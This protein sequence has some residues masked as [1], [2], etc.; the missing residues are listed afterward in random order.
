MNIDFDSPAVKLLKRQAAEILDRDHW[1]DNLTDE[2]IDKVLLGGQIV[3]VTSQIR[4]E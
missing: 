3:Y 1:T 4:K 2:E